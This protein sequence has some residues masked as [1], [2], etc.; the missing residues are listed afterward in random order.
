MRIDPQDTLIGYPILA[1]RNLLRLRVFDASVVEK[2][3]K[4][5]AG[6][7]ARVIGE[8]KKEELICGLRNPDPKRPGMLETTP[9]G[10]RLGLASTRPPIGREKAEAIVAEVLKRTEQVNKLDMFLFGVWEIIVFGSYVTGAD[11]LNDVDFIVKT[12]LKDKFEKNYA[13][14]LRQ[15]LAMASAIGLTI[16]RKVDWQHQ[17]K[18]GVLQFLGRV[19]P[20]VSF[21]RENEL[22]I[23]ER[24]D[25]VNNPDGPPPHAVIYPRKEGSA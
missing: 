21:H 1:I 16:S 25:P 19:S 13:D 23:V 4:V 14:V 15:R 8:L 22:E 9:P 5:D 12:R 18:K 2:V 3:L 10:T 24:D 6:E 7:A 11:E 17:P 20:Y